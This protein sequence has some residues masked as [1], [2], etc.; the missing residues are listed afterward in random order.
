MHYIPTIQSYG[1]YIPTVFTTEHRKNEEWKGFGQ[2][3]KKGQGRKLL[4][5]P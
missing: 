4:N 3:D 5:P 1:K 2:I